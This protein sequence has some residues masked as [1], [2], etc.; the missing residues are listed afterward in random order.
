[1]RQVV[2]NN[3][4]Y[5]IEKGD[6]ILFKDKGRILITDKYYNMINSPYFAIKFNRF[7]YDKK[8]KMEMPY[9]FAIFLNNFPLIINGNKIFPA[10][11][12]DNEQCWAENGFYFPVMK[13][14]KKEKNYYVISFINLYKDLPAIKCFNISIQLF[15]NKIYEK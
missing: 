9:Y 6:L 2:F 12:T 5:N 13:K 7:I 15:K 3:S 1:N 10:F 14:S 11:E 8:Q 4:E